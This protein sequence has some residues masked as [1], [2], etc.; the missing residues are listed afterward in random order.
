MSGNVAQTDG[1]KARG[2]WV[3]GTFR[4]TV[5]SFLSRL[6]LSTVAQRLPQIANGKC[7]KW[8]GDVFILARRPMPIISGLGSWKQGS[9]CHPRL[10]RKSPSQQTRQTNPSIQNDLGQDKVLP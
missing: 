2:T 4:Y 8:T 1:G 10:F 3:N 9:Q 6:Y 7:Q 5:M